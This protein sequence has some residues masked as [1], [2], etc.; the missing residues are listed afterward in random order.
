MGLLGVVFLAAVV[1]STDVAV[2]V[3]A[4]EADAVTLGADELYFPVVRAR[5]VS[6]VLHGF[7][8]FGTGRTL[9][10]DHCRDVAGE[11]FASGLFGSKLGS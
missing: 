8:H 4:G 7:V 9:G 2:G 1:G 11:S 3:Y 10:T 5:M 6:R